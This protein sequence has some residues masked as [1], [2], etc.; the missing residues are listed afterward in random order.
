MSMTSASA[1]SFRNYE[2]MLAVAAASL[3][4][5]ARPLMTVVDLG[6]GTGALLAESPRWR[7]TPR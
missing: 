1:P 3:V 2:E 4:A 5:A 7:G 6:T